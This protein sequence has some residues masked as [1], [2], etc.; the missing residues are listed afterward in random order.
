MVLVWL[1]IKLTDLR[2][3]AI[4]KQTRVGQFGYPFT[5]YKF[6][7]MRVGVTAV[8]TKTPNDTRI[9]RV[10]KWL[11]RTSI[12]ELPQLFNVLIGDLSIVG[13]RPVTFQELPDYDES[14]LVI[15]PGITGLWQVSGRSTTTLERRIELDREYVQTRSTKLDWQILWRTV[16][17]VLAQTGAW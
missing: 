8:G 16:G 13:P 2:A 17:A 4:F 15:K 11:R 9:T 14:V 7:T 12:D 3:P 1:T 10:G 5:I 6:R